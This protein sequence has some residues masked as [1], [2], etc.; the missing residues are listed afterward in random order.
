MTKW[1]SQKFISNNKEIDGL[2]ENNIR[3]YFNAKLSLY[4]I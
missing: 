3:Q 1:H 2:Y 4:K